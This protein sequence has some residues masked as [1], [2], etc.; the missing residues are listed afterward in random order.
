MVIVGR[1]KWNKS[2]KLAESGHMNFISILSV[3]AGAFIG[4]I[5]R[6]MISVWI[7]SDP[8]RFPMSTFL[9]NL[10]GSFIL[11]MVLS[12][13][14]KTE[15]SPNVKLLLATGFCGGFTTFSTFSIEVIQ[16]WQAGQSTVAVWYIL[17]SL[18]G[19]IFVAWIG[20]KIS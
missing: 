1:L 19:G 9:I 2:N 14:L 20:L 10:L 6:Y 12:Y 11:G 18:V 13:A 17:S 16:L 4:G 7:K 3:G 5:L 8:G 15:F